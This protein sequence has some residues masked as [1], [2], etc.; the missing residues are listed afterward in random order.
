MNIDVTSIILA[1]EKGGK[2]INK[3]FGQVLDVEEKSNSSDFRTKADLESEQEIIKVLNKVFP[4]FNIYSEELGKVNNKSNYTFVIDPLDGSNNFV[5]GIPTFCV[6][7]GLMKDDKI[8]A[9]V[10]HHPFLHETYYALK[11]KGAFLQGKRLQV[12][13]EA[14]TN[15]ATVAYT[16][17]YLTPNNFEEKLIHNLNKIKIKRLLQDW[18][19]SYEM[20]L[21]AAGKIEAIINNHNDL[22]DYCAGKIIIKESGGLITDLK[23]HP[24]KNDKSD[25]FIAS[26]GTKI[27]ND[28]L[29]IV[30]DFNY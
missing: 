28:L 14:N 25:V 4:K 30:K 10:I 13:K 9:G 6:S 27:H 11:G 8:V 12:G 19:P 26:N 18:C 29:K 20:C 15:K 7:I 22:Y 17:G 3:Y 16:C 2:V 5:I 24:E 1:A 23:G 21:V